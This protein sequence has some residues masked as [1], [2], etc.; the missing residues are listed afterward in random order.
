MKIGRHAG[1]PVADAGN[2]QER[3]QDENRDES[4]P[5]TRTGRS[6]SPRELRVAR[7]GGASHA[8]GSFEIRPQG[9]RLVA[10][11]REI[12]RKADAPAPYTQ[13]R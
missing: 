11:R 6:S 4:Q 3:E 13:P 10:R 7:S 9:S 12:G 5:G 2:E 8:Q 1:V